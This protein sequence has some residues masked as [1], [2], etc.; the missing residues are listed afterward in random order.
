V[1][2]AVWV[3]SP[4]GSGAFDLRGARVAS[5]ATLLDPSGFDIATDASWEFGARVASGPPGRVAVAYLRSDGADQPRR[6]ALRYL[7][8]G[9]I[10]STGAAQPGDWFAYLHGTVDPNGQATQAWFEWGPTPALGW[11][12]AVHTVPPGGEAQV[13]ESI[14]NLESFTSYYVRLVT[15]NS[16][17]TG[18]GAIRIFHTL[19]TIIPPP[20]P[21]PT[22]HVPRVVG[23]RLVVAKTRIRRAGC[24]VGR[25]RRARSRRV[26]GV[27]LS[28]IPRGG[29][30]VPRRRLVRL[31]VS[32]GR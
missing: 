15:T 7:D 27:V 12:T 23:R 14:S 32:R 10:A 5:D 13:D 21:R 19:D 1:F 8:R 16:S 11:S 4:D 20:N 6:A 29:T 31:V 18:L 9:P 22:C 30:R 24:R 28:Q 17:G 25:I 3:E 2:D 26:R